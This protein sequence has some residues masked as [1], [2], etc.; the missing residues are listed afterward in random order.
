MYKVDFALVAAFP[1]ENVVCI[2][3]EIQSLKFRPFDQ[4]W[5]YQLQNS[6]NF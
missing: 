3:S 6:M 1:S 4:N 2:N 5:N